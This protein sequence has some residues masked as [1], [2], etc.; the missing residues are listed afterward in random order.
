MVAIGSLATRSAGAAGG[1]L[2]IAFS[3]REVEGSPDDRAMR[4]VGDVVVAYSRFRLTSDELSLRQTPHGIEV[5]GHG[6]LVFCSC[7]SPPVAIGFDGAIVAPPADLVIRRP[8]LEIGGVTVFA[9][10]WFWLRGPSKPGLLAPIVAWRG[11]DGLLL[12]DGVHVPWKHG[13]DFDAL[14]LTGAGYLRGGFELTGTLR[15]ERSTTRARWDR[16]NGDLV[17]IDA[18]GSVRNGDGGAVAWDADAI[19]GARARSGTV[20]LG[21]AARGYDRGGFGQTVRP[22]PFVVGAGVGAALA[23][24]GTGLG[25]GWAWGPRLSIAS[26]G[27][28]DGAGTWD[29]LATGT[30][31]SDPAVGTTNL[32]RAETG[33]SL[34]ARPGPL[35]LRGS[36]RGAVTEADAADTTGF[37]AVGTARLEVGLPLARAFDGGAAEAPI[38]H[39][40][41]PRLEAAGLV[42]R[43]SGEW[44]S[45]TGRPVALDGGRAAIGVAGVRTAWGR[46]PGRAGAAI[47]G[48]FGGLASPRGGA[49][50]ARWRTAW[51]SRWIGVGGEG[52]ALLPR[53]GA[54][55][56]VTVARARVGELESWHL[57]A[58][59]AGREGVEP[60]A[61]RAIEGARAL[62][63]SGGW[64]AREGWTGGLDAGVAPLRLLM[65]R[66]GVDEDLS[67]RTLLGVHG[68]IGYH[69]PCGCLT[70][71]LF[72]AHRLGREGLDAWLA[73][74]LAPP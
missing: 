51:G 27:A 54:R 66:A 61:A 26:S 69:H 8:R 43:T 36:L 52:A 58:S 10:P 46:S 1:E 21:E 3:A 41:E 7:A 6:E 59:V 67:T 45:A 13:D 35:S 47:D 57:G 37:D 18:L 15:T 60:I 11:A 17:A 72:A 14:D 38:V 55:G 22:G 44:W 28:L 25:R 50:I 5:A 4:L 74:D 40:V 24:G 39:V 20:D 68:A 56:E 42:A 65:L 32:A 64:L 34:D 48:A 73:I 16:R 12:G 49:A 30:T 2:P 62:E 9:L 53:D 63:P 70:V 71:D 31:L 23:R 19:R 29:A 33:L